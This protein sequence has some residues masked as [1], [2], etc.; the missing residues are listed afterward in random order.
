MSKIASKNSE[1]YFATNETPTKLTACRS[2]SMNTEIGTIDVGTIG[3][4][5]KE[6]LVGQKSV[7]GDFEVLY[8]N[9]AV[10][11]NTALEG[12]MMEGTPITI[13]AYPE[14]KATGKAEYKVGAFI[15]AWNIA[16]ATEDAIT[17]SVS[18]QGTGAMTKGTVSA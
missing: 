13:Y 9:D 16:A 6:F 2:W 15:T 14:G 1:V 12:A 8:D 18:Y 7:S 4:E 17:V 3:T 10:S 11:A 5:W